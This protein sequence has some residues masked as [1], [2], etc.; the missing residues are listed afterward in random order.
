M[1]HIALMDVMIF[2]PCFAI[3][4]WS[5]DIFSKAF[6]AL[7][8]VG[9]IWYNFK[10]Y[11]YWRDNDPDRLHTE[12]TWLDKLRLDYEITSKGGAPGF[13]A[14][15]ILDPDRTSGKVMAAI[16][17]YLVLLPEVTRDQFTAHWD[18]VRP[19]DD[20]FST[21]PNAVFVTTDLT[22]KEISGLF[23]AAFGAQGHFVTRVTEDT[24]GRAAEEY[25]K[26]T[27]PYPKGR[28]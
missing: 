24:W 18:K 23:D 12:K 21:M 20:W 26:R 27:K 9:M 17:T 25:W 2:P 6:C 14:K 15:R 28:L 19:S 22:S 16:Q 5:A 8:I 1:A 7:V 4:Y 13:R 3:I 11:N 10:E